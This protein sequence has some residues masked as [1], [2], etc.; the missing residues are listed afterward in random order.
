MNKKDNRADVAERFAH[1]ITKHE[2]QIVR[3]NGIDRHL[4]FR[5]PGTYCMGFDIIT[6]PG[7]LC[8][9]GDMGT[10]V[11]MRLPD[12]FEFFR[13]EKPNP[14]YWA[15]KVVA[16]DRSDG[17]TEYVSDIFREAVERWM[18]DHF[19]DDGVPLELRENVQEEVLNHADD[20]EYEARRAAIEFE[21]K[22]KTVDKGGDEHD[23]LFRFTDFWEADLRDYTFRFLWCC[24]AL[25]WAI[26][27]YDS[28]KAT[29]AQPA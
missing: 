14:S 17:I 18:V 25:V 12:M 2:M 24:H 6:W 23:H 7:Y 20:G 27:K 9:C 22:W 1:D 13:N 5:R 15:E 29:N 26:K 4:R 10:Y 19:D 28:A 8:Y 21:F 16:Q 3:D 11:F